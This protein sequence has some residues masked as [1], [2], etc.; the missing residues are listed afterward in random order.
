MTRGLSAE[1]AVVLVDATAACVL[2]LLLDGAISALGLRWNPGGL[3]GSLPGGLPGGLLLPLSLPHRMAPAAHLLWSA[4]ARSTHA[5]VIIFVTGSLGSGISPRRRRSSMAAALRVNEVNESETLAPPKFRGGGEPG[6][7]CPRR[8]GGC[9]SRW[10]PSCSTTMASGPMT[11]RVTRRTSR[12]RIRGPSCATSVPP[13]G[14]L[15]RRGQ[16]G[17]AQN[18]V[19]IVIIDVSP[20]LPVLRRPPSAGPWGPC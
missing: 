9:W 15:G 18:L 17:L 5:T 10:W 19:N 16:T 2:I 1:R 13:R 6:A 14:P 11:A 7:P 3:P 12:P 20:L 4:F 8:P